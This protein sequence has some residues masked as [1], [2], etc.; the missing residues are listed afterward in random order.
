MNQVPLQALSSIGTG[1]SWLLPPLWLLHLTHY[2]HGADLLV[3]CL[4]IYLLINKT[5]FVWLVVCLICFVF[6]GNCKHKGGL[7]T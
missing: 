2:R 5:Y 7:Q 6:L 4:L 3:F 1:N